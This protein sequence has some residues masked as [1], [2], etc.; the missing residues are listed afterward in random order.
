MWKS[1]GKQEMLWGVLS[2]VGALEVKVPQPIP[3]EEISP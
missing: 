2:K 3:F 1:F